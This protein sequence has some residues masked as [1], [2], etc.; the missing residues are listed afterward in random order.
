M[1]TGRISLVKFT[2][3]S[4]GSGVYWRSE[5]RKIG[6]HKPVGQ[7]YMVDLPLLVKTKT[8]YIVFTEGLC[9]KDGKICEKMKK[10][11]KKGI[12]FIENFAIIG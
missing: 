10:I 3:D 8:Q 4:P 6:V 12:D 11:F 7:G 5:F 2:L 9:H 1:L